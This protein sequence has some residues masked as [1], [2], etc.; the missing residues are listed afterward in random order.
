MREKIFFFAISQKI[1]SMPNLCRKVKGYEQ[2][3]Q[4]NGSFSR[5]VP[6]QNASV[7]LANS[8]KVQNNTKLNFVA[9]MN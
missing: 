1:F 4:Q 8:I 5:S 2:L 9:L 7:S 6:L 3:F